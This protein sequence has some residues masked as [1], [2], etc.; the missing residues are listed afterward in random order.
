MLRL[1]GSDL[2]SISFALPPR[3]SD[4]AKLYMLLSICRPQHTCLIE[5][6]RARVYKC[7]LTGGANTRIL[8]ILRF[9][10]VKSIHINFP[11]QC[12]VSLTDCCRAH[13]TVCK[14]GSSMEDWHACK[15]SV[16][17][18]PCKVLHPSL[19]ALDTIWECNCHGQCT[20]QPHCK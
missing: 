12:T 18:S 1:S 3:V 20:D 5:C 14:A 11:S 17:L 6:Y 15:F 9:T 13:R 16:Q 10:W 19:T 8:S 7:W 4:W 2:I